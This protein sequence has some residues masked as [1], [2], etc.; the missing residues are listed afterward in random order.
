MGHYHA[1]VLIPSKE[2]VEE[3]VEEIMS[4]YYEE[5]ED[6]EAI[7]LW[8]W[9][10]IGGR[11]K[12]AHDPTYKQEEDPDHI[13]PCR[14]CNATGL[15]EDMGHWED[16]K[17]V[18]KDEWAEKCNGCN[19]CHGTGKELTW[20][21]EWKSHPKD[22]ISINEI[23]EGLTCYTLILPGKVLE[24]IEKTLVKKLLEENGIDEGFLVT[25]DYHC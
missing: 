12:G 23:P 7:K 25:V 21:T 6:E 24:D 15:R 17:K 16:G 4:P 14:Y 9:Y 5:N 8:D 1:E 2:N 11:W 22:T 13:I 20:P 18:F 10:M 19:V 3:Q